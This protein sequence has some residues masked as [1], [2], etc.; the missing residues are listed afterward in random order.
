MDDL[1]DELL[2]AIAAL[3]VASTNR[4]PQVVEDAWP[5]TVLISL[6]NRA[7]GIG[8]DLRRAGRR[9]FHACASRSVEHRGGQHRLA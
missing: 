6:R 2:A 9:G 3:P 8:R 5:D 4:L 1:T 7:R